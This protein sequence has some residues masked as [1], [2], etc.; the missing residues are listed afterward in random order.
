MDN[1]KTYDYEAIEHPNQNL[2]AILGLIVIIVRGSLRIILEERKS[3]I[4]TGKF[5]YQ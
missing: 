3:S 1:A 4:W 2:D 5:M